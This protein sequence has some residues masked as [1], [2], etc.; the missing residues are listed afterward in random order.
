[1]AHAYP[2]MLEPVFINPGVSK[3]IFNGANLM[4]PGVENPQNL[5]EFKADDVRVIISEG[6]KLIFFL[7]PKILN[8]KQ[9]D[10]SPSVPWD[11][12]TPSSKPTIW[13]A[14]QSTFFT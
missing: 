10:P 13:K 1:M 2:K 5:S 4:W 6:T 11:A 14:W 7:N 8:F 3:F 9:I 12:T